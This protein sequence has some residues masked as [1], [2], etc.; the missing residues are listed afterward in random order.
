MAKIKINDTQVVNGKV[1]ASRTLNQ[2]KNG[3]IITGVLATHL[4]IEHISRIECNRYILKNVEVYEESFGSD[5]YDIYYHFTANSLSLKDEMIDGVGTIL[6]GKEMKMI[7]DEMYKDEHPILGA[8]GKEYKDMYI[9]E[10]EEDKDDN[11]ES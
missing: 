2:E 11:R 3:F 4:Y 8:I 7:E 9:D 10:E 5:D 1:S 6:Y